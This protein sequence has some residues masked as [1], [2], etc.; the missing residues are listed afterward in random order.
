MTIVDNKNN[1]Q[2]YSNCMRVLQVAD[3]SAN[4]LIS[5]GNGVIQL[6]SAVKL[7]DVLYCPKVLQTLFPLL[8]LQTWD[9]I[10][11]SIN[12]VVSRQES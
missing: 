4:A 2:N 5:E 10:L 11:F 9:W 1:I 3:A 12:M 8:N 6:N 7:N